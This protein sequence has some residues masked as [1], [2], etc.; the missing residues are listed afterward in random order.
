MINQ[1]LQNSEVSVLISSKK[2]KMLKSS[3]QVMSCIKL[4]LEINKMFYFSIVLAFLCVIIHFV[5]FCY[6]VRLS[7][8]RVESKQTK[9]P[10]GIASS[11][12]M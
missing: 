4:K 1:G 7:R 12:Y 11:Q 9:S 10:D 3:T 8:Y 5:I 2:L 6:Y